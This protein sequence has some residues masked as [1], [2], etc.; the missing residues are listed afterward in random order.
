M[1]YYDLNCC[2]K[3]TKSFENYYNHFMIYYIKN[4]GWEIS[5]ELI[6]GV[7]VTLVRWVFFI[8]YTFICF[9]F[10]CCRINQSYVHCKFNRSNEYNFVNRFYRIYFWLLTSEADFLPLRKWFT[11]DFLPLR[12]WFTPS[13]F[14][15]R[16]KW[17]TPARPPLRKWLNPDAASFLPRKKWFTGFDLEY[18]G[19]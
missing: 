7:H 13:A 19:V 6:K 11:A 10:L 5:F 3:N 14:R 1:Q 2:C 8:C 4:L 16:K 18:A 15:P 12:K 9:F 17:L